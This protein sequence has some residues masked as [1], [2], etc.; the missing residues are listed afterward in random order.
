MAK[1]Y[2]ML[3]RA[4]RRTL[5]NIPTSLKEEVAELLRAN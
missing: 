2:A 3:I 5:D 1:I 4:G